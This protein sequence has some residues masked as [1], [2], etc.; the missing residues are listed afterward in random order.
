MSSPA[1]DDVE[2]AY[3]RFEAAQARA[4]RIDRCYSIGSFTVR[5]SFAGPALLPLLSS[6]LAHLASDPHAAADLTICAW[7]GTA[8]APTTD[9]SIAPTAR[10]HR[11][12]DVHVLRSAGRDEVSVLYEARNLGLYWAPTPAAIPPHVTAAPFVDIFHWWM[13][14]RGA[15][16]VHAAALGTAAGGVLLAGKGGAGKSTTALACA[17][18]DLRHAADDYCLV[19]MG[20]RP[21]V[22][23][24]YSSAKIHRDHLGRFSELGL[25]AEA[26]D[27]D[28]AILM[29]HPRATGTLISGFPIRAILLVH[30][31]GRA[32]T[33]LGDATPSAVVQA[34]A[35][36]TLLQL[37]A[38]DQRDLSALAELA[39][40]VPGYVLDAGTDFRQLKRTIEALCVRSDTP[41]HA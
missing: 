8:G 34:L 21:R 27:E 3:R 19:E 26:F 7:D 32:E 38:A 36:S 4:G 39:R 11:A 1:G 14:P 24:L 6:A 33:V 28:K 12:A 15:Y 20:H 35:P 2:A 9:D 5:V 13:R 22:S 16:V 31:S 37:K 41:R 18:V 30:V 40:R 23:S 10:Y 17:G 29:L 25:H